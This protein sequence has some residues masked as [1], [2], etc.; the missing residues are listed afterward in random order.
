MQLQ[1]IHDMLIIMDSI[2]NLRTFVAVAEEGSFAAAARKLGVTPQLVSKYIQALEAELGVALLTR[3]TRKVNKTELG[4]AYYSRCVSL[5]ED[6]DDMRD[7]VRNEHIEPRGVLNV[8]APVTFGEIYLADAL[9]AF[10]KTYPEISFRI[11]FTDAFVDLM[12]DKIDVAIR[13]GNLKNSALI[14]RKIATAKRIICASPDYLK[15]TQ[16]PIV[17]EDLS[18][19]ECILDTNFHQPNQWNFIRD[20][21]PY[22]VPVS[23]KFTVN[24]ATAAIGLG[25]N[26]AGILMCPEIFVQDELASGAL[27][28]IELGNKSEDAGVYAIFHSA[29]KPAA[30]IR[31]FV[32][33][34]KV[35]LASEL[36]RKKNEF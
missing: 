28:Q 21:I 2:T 30:K 29:R 19:H 27:V 5:L 36:A 16:L 25:R 8:T 34:M 4:Q 1:S 22:T 6:F 20:G 9:S 3:T 18:K 11:Q 7:F 17:P 24:S 14:A 15:E 23:G 33:F 26:N 32:D 35:H 12:A 13:I 10:S 31:A